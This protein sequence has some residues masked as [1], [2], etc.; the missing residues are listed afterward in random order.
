MLRD[1]GRE[2]F[3]QTMESLVRDALPASIGHFRSSER[4]LLIPAGNAGCAASA[5]R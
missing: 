5:C 2:M 4:S 3:V 1:V